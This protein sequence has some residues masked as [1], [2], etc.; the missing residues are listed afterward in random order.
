MKAKTHS[1][2]KKRVKVT[3]NKKVIFKKPGRNHLLFNKSKG[4]KR[5]FKRGVQVKGSDLN[6]VYSM[7]KI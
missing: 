6:N 1:G 2:L 4:Q 3:R 5:G 7:L